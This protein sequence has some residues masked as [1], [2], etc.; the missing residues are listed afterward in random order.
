MDDRGQR[1]DLLLLIAGKTAIISVLFD[2]EETD[3]KG[4]ELMA[5]HR[6]NVY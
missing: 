2:V 1:V 6:I 3:S 5:E 4:Q